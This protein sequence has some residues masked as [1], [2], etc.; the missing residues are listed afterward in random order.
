MHCLPAGGPASL[1]QICGISLCPQ[2]P[3]F[4]Q[5]LPATRAARADVRVHPADAW[6]GTRWLVQGAAPSVGPHCLHHRQTWPDPA[7]STSH[8]QGVCC[9]VGA[10]TFVG[11]VALRLPP[12]SSLPFFSSGEVWLCSWN[13]R[14]ASLCFRWVEANLLLLPSSERWLGASPKRSCLLNLFIN[15]HCFSEH[16]PSRVGL[17]LFPPAQCFLSHAVATVVPGL[18]Q[19]IITASSEFCLV[20]FLCLIQCFFISCAVYCNLSWVSLCTP[21]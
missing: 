4:R 5:E 2:P 18:L 15:R 13:R 6:W 1:S 17:A 8:Y 10:G 7:G 9:G 3:S 20:S 12:L 21:Q 11:T 16:R 14:M 19:N